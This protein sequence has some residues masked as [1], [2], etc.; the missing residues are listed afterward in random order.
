MNT[1]GERI[2]WLRKDQN[3][4]QQ[5]F[6]DRLA[7]KRNTI[8]SYEIGRNMPLD[9]VIVLICREFNANESWLRHGV[10]DMYRPVNRDAEISAFVDEIMVSQSAD[11][12]RRLVAVLARLDPQEWKLLERM[13]LKLADEARREAPPQLNIVKIAGRD[14]SFAEH[15]MTGDEVEALQ[16]QLEQLPDASDDL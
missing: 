12:R 4:T 6:A 9:A 7:I 5:E 8:A 1:I 3:M 11:F 10:G 13:A 16:A 2:K 14:G 15:A